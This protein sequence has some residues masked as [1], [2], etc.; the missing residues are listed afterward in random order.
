MPRALAGAIK[1]RPT[2]LQRFVLITL[3]LTAIASGFA[4]SS[5]S[6]PATVNATINVNCPFSIVLSPTAPVFIRIGYIT[7]NYSIKSSVSCSAIALVGNFVLSNITTDATYYTTDLQFNSVSPIPINGVIAVNAVNIPQSDDKVAMTLS[8]G[9]FSNFS[10]NSLTVLTPAVISVNSLVVSPSSPGIDAQISI[11]TNTVNL[12]SLAAT[13]MLLNLTITG[14]GLTYT[15]NQVLPSLSPTQSE[16]T[17]FFI[18]GVTSNYGTYT[19]AANVSYQTIFTEN[20]VTYT[21]NQISTTVYSSYT[22]P[23]PTSPPS[24]HGGGLPPNITITQIPTAISTLVFEQMPIIST[25]TPGNSTLAQVA[26]YNND[27]MPIWVNITVPKALQFGGV[28]L[29]ATSIYILPNS[30][31]FVELLISAFKNATQNTYL[32]IFNTT[33]TAVGEKPAHGQFYTGVQVRTFQKN[34]P[35]VLRSTTYTAS[36]GRV[37][38]Q[39]SVYNPFNITLYS[40]TISAE[41]PTSITTNPLGIVLSGAVNNV[42]VKN[43]EYILNWRIPILQPHATSILAFTINNV[44]TPQYFFNPITSTSTLSQY[45]TT[46]LRVFNIVA[47]TFYVNQGNNITVSAIYTGTNATNLTF[48]LVPPVDIVVYNQLQVFHAF[49]NTI[50]D[51]KFWV[52][53]IKASGTYLFNLLIRGTY[54]NQSFSIPVIVLQ[55]QTAAVPPTNSVTQVGAIRTYEIAT[56][57]VLGAAA[58]IVVALAGYVAYKRVNVP[59]YNKGRAEEMSRMKQRVKREIAEEGKPGG[60]QWGSP[61]PLTP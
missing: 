55:N 20:G 36:T 47:P 57:I 15:T 35:V 8:Y 21:Y 23:S 59:R 48:S 58:L 12:G 49:P 33:V 6:P 40:T 32:V 43:G 52:A 30:T 2:Y 4:A 22:I 7:V 54:S 37:L 9:S 39:Y 42:T 5:S 18:T 28:N 26:L 34:N 53:P 41:L 17:Q 50:I 13:N 31:Q 27:N 44:T 60:P 61:P 29:S 45:N 10:T 3:V 51:A 14:P 11:A 56:E 46:R 25:V 16:S 38:T 1:M 19:V 24:P